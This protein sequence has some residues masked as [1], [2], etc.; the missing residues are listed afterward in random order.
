MAPTL[1][2]LQ[3]VS[4]SP[5]SFIPTHEDAQVEESTLKSEEVKP[6][7]QASAHHTV[8]HSRTGKSNAPGLKSRTAMSYSICI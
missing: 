4:Y 2:L 3:W 5:P 1:S 8:Q 6:Y 7:K